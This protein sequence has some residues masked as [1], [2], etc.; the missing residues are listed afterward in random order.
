[1]AQ[2]PYA[3]NYSTKEGFPTSTVYNVTQDKYGF[4]WFSTDAGI[5]KYDSHQFELI[6]TDKGLSDNEVFQMKTDSKGRTWML[7]LT[8]KLSFLYKNKLYN[9]ANSSVVKQASGT[10]ITVNF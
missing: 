3:I 9:E 5:I 8:G 7:T 1:M 4:L 2:E 6:N 10:S